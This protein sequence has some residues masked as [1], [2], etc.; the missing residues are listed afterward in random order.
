MVREIGLGSEVKDNDDL[1]IYYNKI[2]CSFFFCLMSILT[3]TSFFSL[4]NDKNEEAWLSVALGLAFLVVSLVYLRIIFRKEPALSIS[5]KDIK[6]H[7][8]WTNKFNAVNFEDIEKIGTKK[9]KNNK[10]VVL[11]LK[12]KN[13][14]ELE[15]KNAFSSNSKDISTALLKGYNQDKLAEILSEKIGKING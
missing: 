10:F 1:K 13:E 8:I 9:V 11:Y 7:S 6:I 3:I 4:L 15:I 5:D 12:K 14:D 2:I